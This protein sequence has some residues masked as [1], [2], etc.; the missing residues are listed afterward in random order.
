MIFFFIFSENLF[1][2]I[3]NVQ[4]FRWLSHKNMLISE[5]ESYFENPWYS[6]LK[7][8]MFF[9]LI[10]PIKAKPFAVLR[11]KPTQILP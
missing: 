7:E 6:F 1:R 9:L 5:T 4:N 3:E 2:S 8:P 10:K 11:Q